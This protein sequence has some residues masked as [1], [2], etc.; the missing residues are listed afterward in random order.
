MNCNK[1]CL[2]ENGFM[3]ACLV[4]KLDRHYIIVDAYIQNC[5][6]PLLEVLYEMPSTLKIAPKYL[7][8][9]TIK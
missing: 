4:E 6:Q 8:N 1:K 2:K 5:K 7:I 9:S 3:P